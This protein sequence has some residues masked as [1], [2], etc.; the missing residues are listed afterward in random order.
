VKRNGLSAAEKVFIVLVLMA[1]CTSCQAGFW[2]ETG[3]NAGKASF[4]GAL[5]TLGAVYLG[6]FGAFAGG[7]MGYFW[8][9][10]TERD[11]NAETVQRN[12]W[13]AAGLQKAI[14]DNVQPYAEAAE[15]ARK[16]AETAE[17]WTD[18]LLWGFILFVV[19]YIM[20]QFWWEKRTDRKLDD[21][22]NGQ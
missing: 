16:V 12:L 1:T 13:D 4:P 20:K 17:S 10:L 22:F 3:D 11:I 15:K 8:V 9:S 6:P 21:R 5:A 19:M 2:K 18:Y 7:M 14:N